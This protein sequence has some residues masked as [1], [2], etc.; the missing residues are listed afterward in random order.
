MLRWAVRSLLD[1]RASLIASIAGVAAAFLLAFVIQALFAG[2]AEKIVAYPTRTDADVWVMQHGVSNMHMATS[3]V[4]SQQ[5]SAI[6]RVEGV[7][8]VTS[9]L[10]VNTFV[11]AGGQDWFSYVIGL[12][13]DAARGGPWLMS[14]GKPRP[15]PGEVVLSDVLAHRAGIDLGAI[16]RIDKREFIVVGLAREAYSMANSLTFVSYSDLA[17]LLSSPKG[18]SYF[19]VKA[20][21]ATDPALLA[22][23]IATQFPDL[24]ALTRTELVD[25]DRE[26]A[27]QMGVEI[28]QM[29]NWIASAVA[30]LV[31]AFTIYSSVVRRTA[32]L[33]MVKAIG[34][35]KSL[36]YSAVLLQTAI[37][38][39]AGY[40]AAAFV[41][42]G[43]TPALGAL[44]P[45]VSLLFPWWNITG[46]TASVAVVAIVSAIVP[47]RR[48]AQLD[49]A[50][51]FR[52]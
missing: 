42:L 17:E 43:L 51:A 3:L 24:N 39:M 14:R 46:F 16:V 9:I 13:P 25:N 50:T 44:V 28:V 8:G 21:V 31:I 10:Y 23:R 2:E 5:A 26:L 29:M 15:G 34:A 19:L 20:A 18:A 38:A 27:L 37:V 22:R 4:E 36:V 11:E 6:T 40:A 1:E 47:A 33:G 49:P 41:S 35:S 30:A 45:E 32:E 48:I 52:A 12:P 7:A